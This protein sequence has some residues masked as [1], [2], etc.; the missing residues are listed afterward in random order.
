MS[1]DPNILGKSSALSNEERR[2]NKEAKSFKLTFKVRRKWSRIA[3]DK[4]V[5]AASK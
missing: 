3:E 1:A 5:P 4:R 2:A